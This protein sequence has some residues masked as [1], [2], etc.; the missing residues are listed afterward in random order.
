[1]SANMCSLN[2]FTTYVNDEKLFMNIFAC[3]RH[4]KMHM[5]WM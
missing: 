5:M 4:Y 1:M 3:L 2:I